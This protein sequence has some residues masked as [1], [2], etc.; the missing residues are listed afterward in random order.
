LLYIPILTLTAQNSSI[1]LNPLYP[2]R[3]DR[4]SAITLT[5]GAYTAGLCLR[6]TTLTGYTVENINA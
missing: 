1:A 6:T 2:I 5:M 3:L 4:G